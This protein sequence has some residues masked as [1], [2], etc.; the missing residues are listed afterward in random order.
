[1][2]EGQQAVATIVRDSLASSVHED[3]PARI[4]DAASKY[5]LCGDA[6]RRI[7]ATAWAEFVN[8]SVYDDRL[9][10]HDAEQ[11][12]LKVKDQFGL[13]QSELDGDGAYTAVTKSS[14]VRELLNGI[15]PRRITLEGPLPIN[16]QKTE[17]LVWVFERVQFLED[18]TRRIYQGV[19]HGVS[20][21]VMKGV[22]YRVSAFKGI[23]IERTERI[24][25]DDGYGFATTKHFYFAGSSKSL[26]IPYQ[27]IVTFHPFADGVGI[28]RDT[29][30][31]KMQA[32]ITGDGWFTYNVLANL[33]RL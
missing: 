19:S 14:I 29:A 6:T 1:M 22:Y 16:L 3:L 13:S 21:R 28:I 27:K 15:V 32:F 5:S 2:L 33:A 8:R 20:V 18:R 31:A 23:P 17:Q 9:I 30:S 11:R 4:D 10:D 12:L 7:V 24:H 25:V 26:R